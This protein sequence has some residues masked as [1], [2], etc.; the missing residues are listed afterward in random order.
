[1]HHSNGTSFYTAKDILAV[2]EIRR[3][4]LKDFAVAVRSYAQYFGQLKENIKLDRKVLHEAFASAYCDMYRLTAFRG[5]R[6]ADIHKKS[7]FLI[8]WIAKLRP[9]HIHH[10]INAS[11]IGVNE[12]FAITIALTLMDI[13]PDNLLDNPR[14]NKYIHNLMYLL[15]YHDCASEQLA[16][17]LFLLEMQ[18][19]NVL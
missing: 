11:I 3:E 4:F 18:I 17:E 12:S 9:V 8:K 13:P 6:N 19:T 7:A 2:Q 5:I 1:M 16:S 10:Y 14:L 15:H